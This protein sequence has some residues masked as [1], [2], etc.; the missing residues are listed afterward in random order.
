MHG[1]TSAL[2]PGGIRLG[3]PALTS[4]GFKE[5]EMEK[6]AEFLHR[7]MQIALNVQEKV[8]KK[9]ADFLPALENNEELKT[10]RQEVEAF[11]RNYPLPG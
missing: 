6:V 7:G 2:V 3:T 4:R 9:L 1:D 5:A 8:G 10:L 11:A